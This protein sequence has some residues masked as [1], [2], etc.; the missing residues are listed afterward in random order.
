MYTVGRLAKEF[1][2][3]R[4]TLLYYDS[5]GLLSPSQHTK[6]TYRQY[7]EADKEKL[8]RICMYRKAGVSLK[9]IARILNPETTS[10]ISVVLEDRLEALSKEIADLQSQQH[11]VTDLLQQSTL[12]ASASTTTTWAELFTNAGLS[13]EDMRRWHM[14]FERLRPEEHVEFLRLLHMPEKEITT[15]RSWAAAPQSILKLQKASEEFMATFFR[16]Y[17]GVARKG[18][19]SLELTKKALALCADRPQSPSILNIGCGSG[20]D[21]V[22]LALLCDG[23]ITAV[24]IYDPFLQETRENAKAAN[25]ADRIT[26]QCEDMAKLPFNAEQFDIIW[27]EGAAYIMGVDNA[28]ESWKKFLK[29]K[30]YLVISEAVWLTAT[31]D[32]EIKNF[33]KEAYPAMRT[34]QENITAIKK[35]G[36]EL[37]GNFVIPDSAWET[38]YNTLEQHLA[39]LPENL[40]EEAY[41][42]DILA[43]TTREIELYRTFKNQYGYEFY[44]IQVG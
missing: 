40:L 20:N 4:S 33:W 11:I 35:H 22:D 5:I 14:E 17:E 13:T 9:N 28:L 8:R 16:F 38:F 32:E 36:Y 7:T 19:G 34:T 43:L 25:V 37:L 12:P 24:D 27:S 26:T 2:L 18:P 41:A 30:G 3:S 42:K 44:V 31:P 21:A 23:H 15:I 39:N 6:G 1:G 29:T 10:E